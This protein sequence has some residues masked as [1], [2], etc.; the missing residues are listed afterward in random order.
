M[1]LAG[2]IVTAL[3]VLGAETALALHVA[4]QLRRSNLTLLVLSLV[5][6]TGLLLIAW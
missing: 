2:V 5:L 1:F 6:A 4:G 3:A